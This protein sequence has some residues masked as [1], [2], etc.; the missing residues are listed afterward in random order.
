M[1]HPGNRAGL[2]HI[3]AILAKYVPDFADRAIA[4]I[5][6]NVNQYGYA[7]WAISFQRK[8]LVSRARQFAGAALNRTLDVIGRH[9]LC[10]GR[11]NGPA[12]ARIAVRIAPAVLGRNGY[13]LDKTGKNLTPFGVQSAFLMLDCGPF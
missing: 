10:L 1:E 4:I 12:Q 8:L 3:S 7:P 6:V 2:R 11:G 13:F 5:S 9:V